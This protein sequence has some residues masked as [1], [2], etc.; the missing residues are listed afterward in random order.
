[1]SIGQGDRFTFDQLAALGSE[2][3]AQL[4]CLLCQERA[5]GLFFEDIA[6]TVRPAMGDGEGADG[7]AVRFEEH[8]RL[9]LVHP[10]RHGRC[11]AAQDHAV[12]QVMDP[13]QRG[14]TA[15]DIQLVDR[16][17]AHERGHQPAQSQD[18]IEMAVGEQDAG[19]VLEPRARLQDLT[20]GAF[21]TIHQKTIFVVLDD[22]GRESP[23]G[24][25]RG[26]GCSEEEYF[27]QYVFLN[28]VPHNLLNL[29]LDSKL[30][31][32]VGS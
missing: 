13:V 21:T 24:R 9:D 22:L 27:E 2:R 14:A 32:T 18:V 16:L 20:L 3:D 26:S 30:H 17:P 31:I 5:A 19:Q 12:H 15:E 4:I 29:W 11:V 28:G 1:M 8:A 10:H 7:E 25:R 23:L 6:Q